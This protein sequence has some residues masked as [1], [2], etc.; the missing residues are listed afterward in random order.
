MDKKE[1]LLAEANCEI[2]KQKEADKLINVGVDIGF[3][4]GDYGER[5]Y[6]KYEVKPKCIRVFSIYLCENCKSKIEER[7]YFHVDIMP[8]FKDLIKEVLIK[9]MIIEGLK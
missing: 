5:K 9:N 6:K 2:C 7:G 4:I 1:E 3:H 8:Q